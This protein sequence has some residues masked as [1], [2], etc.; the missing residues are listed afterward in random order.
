[1]PPTPEEDEI[2]AAAQFAA[3]TVRHLNDIDEHFFPWRELDLQAG[4]GTS[5]TARFLELA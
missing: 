3:E 1:M 4:F 5:A 2:R